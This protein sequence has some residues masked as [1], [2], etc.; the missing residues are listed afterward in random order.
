[1]NKQT[2]RVADIRKRCGDSNVRF[3]DVLS[4]YGFVSTD[5]Q[6]VNEKVSSMASSIR[7]V[8]TIAEAA[9][10]LTLL[11][12]K[13]TSIDSTKVEDLLKDLNTKEGA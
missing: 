7:R 4:K 2:H 11:A 12:L 8:Q 9:K 3:A 10:K 13:E 5:L 1:M 6:S